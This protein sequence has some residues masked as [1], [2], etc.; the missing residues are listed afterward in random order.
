[1]AWRQSR[2][3]SLSKIHTTSQL[4]EQGEAEGGRGLE[5][6]THAKLAQMTTDF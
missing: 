1:M 6:K 2:L 3:G 5:K 4:Q